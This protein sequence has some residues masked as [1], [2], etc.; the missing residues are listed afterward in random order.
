MMW[1]FETVGEAPSAITAS[2]TEKS[3]HGSTGTLE[4]G[5]YGSEEA[6]LSIAKVVHGGLA[7]CTNICTYMPTR[8]TAMDVLTYSDTRAKLRE[9]MD[10]VVDDH[11]PIVI[12]RQKAEAVV[13]V[14]LADWN[15]ME[16]TLHLLSTPSNA[17]RLREAIAELDAGQGQDRD[18][19]EP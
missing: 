19:V 17:E 11:R 3:P 10:R 12:T 2:K 16:E 8:R 18:L 13:M 6:P 5:A 7:F 4:S 1:S 14:S 9:V 15:A